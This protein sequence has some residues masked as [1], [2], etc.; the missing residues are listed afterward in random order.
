ME[1][2]DQFAATEDLAAEV[3]SFFA[4]QFAIRWLRLFSHHC[5]TRVQSFIDVDRNFRELFQVPFE[6]SEIRRRCPR[7]EP[8]FRSAEFT[9]HDVLISSILGDTFTQ[10]VADQFGVQNGILSYCTYCR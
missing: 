6:V 2:V 4:N 5:W 3:I 1:L 10:V 9:D 8:I 7:L